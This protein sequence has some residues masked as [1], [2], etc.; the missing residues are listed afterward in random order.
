MTDIVEF[1]AAR[2]DEDEAAARAATPGPW[3][4]GD[5]HSDFGTIEQERNTL[6]HA[7][8]YGAFPVVRRREDETALVLRIEDS[9]EGW[10][11]ADANAE[12]IARHDPAR[13]LADITAKRAI[14]AYA[15]PTLEPQTDK[16]LHARHAH[17]AYEYE[18]T[19]GQ[20]KAWDRA[21]E[22]PE[23]DGWE[24]NVDAGRDGWDRLDYTEESYWR[25]PLPDGPPPPYVP[26]VLCHLATVYADH[27]DYD[28]RWRT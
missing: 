19:E 21:D 11:N 7:P 8:G 9:L 20:R 5:W 24:R 15:A 13:V 22:P 4:W 25:R 27:P 23:G 28:E 6:E 18:T 3:R 1:L 14:I 26:T 17:P 2:L 10:D 16:Q 12:H